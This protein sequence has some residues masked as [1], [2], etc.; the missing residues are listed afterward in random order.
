[1]KYAGERKKCIDYAA[2]FFAF[3]ASVLINNNFLA[4][5]MNEVDPGKNLNWIIKNFDKF[6][7]S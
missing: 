2:F 7:G 5:A 4:I 6:W 3:N 1:M